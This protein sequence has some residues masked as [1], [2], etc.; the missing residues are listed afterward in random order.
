[1]FYS[2]V[3]HCALGI[4]INPIV[5]WKVILL[6]FILSKRLEMMNQICQSQIYYH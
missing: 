4:Q 6:V 1:M 3:M 5:H 2:S